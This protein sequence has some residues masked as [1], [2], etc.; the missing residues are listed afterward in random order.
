MVTVTLP[1]VT[2]VDGGPVSQ[3]STVT[4]SV[5]VTNEDMASVG[6]PC[7]AISASDPGVS[8]ASDEGPED[9]AIPYGMTVG[10]SGTA[11]IGAQVP[12]GSTIHMAAW[13]VWQTAPIDGDECAGPALEWDVA[14]Q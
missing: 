5:Q 6:Y 8:F 4:W 3:G 10:F 9:F 2:G 14:V 12:A 11:T 7:V 1:K 13:T